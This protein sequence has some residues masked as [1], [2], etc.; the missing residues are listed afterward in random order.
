LIVIRRAGGETVRRQLTTV[1]ELRTTNRSRALW[2]LYLRGA[3]SRQQIGQGAGFS[4][5]TVSNV[6]GELITQRLVVEVGQE[7]SNGGRPRALVQIA[8]GYGHVVGVDIGETSFLVEL[9]DL[10]MN[11]LASH[12]SS[13]ALTRLDAQDAVSH[14]AEGVEQVLGDARL[15]AGRVL[16]IGVG[17]PGPVEHRSDG[18]IVHGQTVGWDEVPF[19]QLLRDRVGLPVLVENGAKT[20]GQAESWFGAARDI[21]HSVI[22]LLGIGVG[23]GIVSDRA[24]YRGATS[25]A[26]EW[27]HTTIVV[28]GRPCRCGALGCLESYVGGAAVVA[29]YDE[30]AGR[31]RTVRQRDLERR[32]EAM[33]AARA[34]DAIAARVFDETAAYLG[35]GIANLVNLFN[36]TRVVI[37]GWL[38]LALADFLLPRI[39]AVAVA[40]ALRLP[41]SRLEIVRAELGPD[42]VALGAATLP[43]AEFLNNGGTI[44]TA[45]PRAQRRPVRASR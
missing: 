12:R 20:L 13:T 10:A 31:N 44:R 33:I 15:S 8:P 38:G 25:S 9:F 39:R 11:V 37:G 7:D 32:V 41:V 36:P 4:L 30:L 34:D 35:V 16:G 29:R 43:I 22:A 5:A 19:E 2:E 18:A 1:R 26:G 14:V 3:L 27:G 42:A 24:L 40:N 17:V 28:D 21:D 23:A 6:L 45:A